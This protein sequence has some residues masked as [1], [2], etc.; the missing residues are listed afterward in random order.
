MLW[1]EVEPAVV[2]SLCYQVIYGFHTLTSFIDCSN[3]TMSWFSFR[4][5]STHPQKQH[6]YFSSAGWRSFASRDLGSRSRHLQ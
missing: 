4:R 5:T 3:L 2:I 1:R 6:E